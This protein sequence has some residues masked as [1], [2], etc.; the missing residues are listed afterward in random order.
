MGVILLKTFLILTSSDLKEAPIS[1]E[2]CA[3]SQLLMGCLFKLK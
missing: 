3:W 2:G 1:V